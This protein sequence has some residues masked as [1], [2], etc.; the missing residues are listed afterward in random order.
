M[1]NAMAVICIWE[2]AKEIPVGE[3]RLELGKEGPLKQIHRQLESESTGELGKR[4]R[5]PTEEGGAGE[6]SHLRMAESHSPE[7]VHSSLRH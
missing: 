4:C 3:I 2:S 7:D 6:L 5:Y 1:G